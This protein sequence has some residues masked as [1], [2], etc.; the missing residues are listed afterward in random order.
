M[1]GVYAVCGRQAGAVTQSQVSQ[2]V[3]VCVCVCVCVVYVLRVED[4]QEL[5]RKAR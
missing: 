3:A 1:C 5:L 4:K 2:G